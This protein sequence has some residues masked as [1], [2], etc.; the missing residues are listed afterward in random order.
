MIVT[1]AINS[2]VNASIG[3][4]RPIDVQGEDG[5]S[6][7]IS[8]LKSLGKYKSARSIEDQNKV[9]RKELKKKKN[10]YFKQGSFVLLDIG[11]DGKKIEKSYS[12]KVIIFLFRLFTF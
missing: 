5:N 8:R 7:V 9:L 2:S 1:K 6:I 4:L 11:S 10:K 3:N 12:L